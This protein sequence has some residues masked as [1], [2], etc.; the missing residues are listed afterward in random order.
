M[1]GGDLHTILGLTIAFLRLPPCTLILVPSSSSRTTQFSRDLPLC[2][3]LHPFD[4]PLLL[5][6]LA[7]PAQYP[8]LNY[9]LPFSWGLPVSLPLWL[10]SA[11]FLSP[12]QSS[13]IFRELGCDLACVFVRFLTHART[14]APPTH[15]S[16]CSSSLR[17]RRFSV[18]WRHDLEVQSPCLRRSSVPQCSRI[19]RRI[20][21]TLFDARMSYPLAAASTTIFRSLTLF[22]VRPVESVFGYRVIDLEL[23]REGFRIGRRS[24]QVC[25]PLLGEHVLQR[26]SCRVARRRCNPSD[27]DRVSALRPLCVSPSAPFRSPAGPLIGLFAASHCLPWGVRY[28]G[29][30]AISHTVPQNLRT[31]RTPVKFVSKHTSGFSL[32]RP[33]LQSPRGQPRGIPRPLPF[34]L[35]LL[36]S[37]PSSSYLPPFRLVVRPDEYRLAV[38]SLVI[39]PSLLPVPFTQSLN[40]SNLGRVS[41]SFVRPA[42]RLLSMMSGTDQIRTC[43]IYTLFL[44]QGGN[45]PRGTE[46]S[47]SGRSAR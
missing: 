4:L 31:P 36:I 22:V 38:T 40:A 27:V 30:A 2:L 37:S 5:A 43:F 46:H 34:F 19:P 44:R 21:F 13:I 32:H 10:R 11:P 33:S 6:R 24:A 42:W 28:R 17:M 15:S 35:R 20:E 3:S 45:P 18:V 29:C 14:A 8:V 1:L 23:K 39:L 16:G 47:G 25:G 9:F 41:L 12:P 26:V 7:R